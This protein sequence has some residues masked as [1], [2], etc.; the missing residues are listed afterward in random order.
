MYPS[1]VQRVFILI[2][3]NSVLPKVTEWAEAGLLNISFSGTQGSFFALL[4]NNK[5]KTYLYFLELKPENAPS[6]Y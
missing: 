1:L 4:Q 6:L 2:G 3:W 5:P